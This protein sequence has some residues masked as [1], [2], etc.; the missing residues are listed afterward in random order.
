MDK[1]ISRHVRVD[2]GE[3][4]RII[5]VLNEFDI[6]YKINTNLRRSMQPLP[7]RKMCAIQ[8]IEFRVFLLLN[9]HRKCIQIS[10]N[11]TGMG[12]EMCGNLKI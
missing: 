5:K 4:F 1:A 3:L 7:E 12:L 2:K 11:M 6:T 10:T 8:S 9:Y